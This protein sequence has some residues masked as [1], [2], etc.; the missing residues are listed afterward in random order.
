MKHKRDDGV[1]KQDEETL[2]VTPIMIC[3]FVV[4]CCSML[5]LLYFFYDSLGIKKNKKKADTTKQAM[6]YIRID[7]RSSHNVMFFW[8]CCSN[9]GD[10]HFLPGVIR[11]ALQLLVAFCA[12]LSFLQVQVRQKGRRT[13]NAMK[14]YA[15]VREP[16]QQNHN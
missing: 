9:L 14:H 5:V 16:R 8:P 7:V 4:M 15:W 1:D 12:P 2:D 10:S 11:G 13:P 6:K 3:V